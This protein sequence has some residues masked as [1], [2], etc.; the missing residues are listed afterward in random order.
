MIRLSRNDGW[1]VAGTIAI[2]VC[3][4]LW[5]RLTGGLF[6]R[7]AVG[8]VTER[9][10][11]ETATHNPSVVVFAVRES[12]D[13]ASAPSR[14]FGQPATLGFAKRNNRWEWRAVVFERATPLALPDYFARV[15]SENEY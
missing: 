6:T 12:G 1:F 9:L 7:E 15:R 11:E 10:S 4:S 13:E 8:I 5:S 14:L 2:V 3:A